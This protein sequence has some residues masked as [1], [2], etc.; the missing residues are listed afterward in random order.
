MADFAQILN[1]SPED[2]VRLFYRI[3][4]STARGFVAKIDHTAAQLELNHS[5][6]ICAL[7]FNKHLEE[8]IDILSVLGFSSAKLLRYRRDELFIHDVYHQLSIDDVLDIY[9][10]CMAEPTVLLEVQHL[11]QQRLS[12]IESA[13]KG[14]SN[15][16]ATISFKMELHVVYSSEI[17]TGAFAEQ[18]IMSKKNLKTATSMWHEEIRL[19]VENSVI[20]AGNLF[21]SEQLSP[22][23]KLVLI[24]SGEINISMIKN[25]MQNTTITAAER[26]MLEDHLS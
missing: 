2:L 21:F 25:R 7:G 22:E 4:Q 23:E 6:L 26:D 12:E 5:Q 17:A 1:A 13:I 11:L 8:L 14:L 16:N 20:P 24:E 19:I 3:K 10:F 18:R 9:T 15:P